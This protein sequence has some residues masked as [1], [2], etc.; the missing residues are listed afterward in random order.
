MNLVW[1][2]VMPSC[3]SGACAPIAHALVLH[4]VDEVFVYLFGINFFNGNEND[5]ACDIISTLTSI[6]NS[7]A[8]CSQLNRSLM[9]ADV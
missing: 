8:Q 2:C 5:D 7:P 4:D 3:N 1:C 6:F 9:M